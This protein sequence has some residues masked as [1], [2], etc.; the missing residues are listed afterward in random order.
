MI[1]LAK[2]GWVILILI[3]TGGIIVVP[4]IIVVCIVL[5]FLLQRFRPEW[6]TFSWDEYERIKKERLKRISK[7]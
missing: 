2:W 7:K 3:L 5:Y 6:L 1:E 4:I